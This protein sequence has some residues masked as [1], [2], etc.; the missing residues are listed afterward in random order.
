MK[1]IFLH[2]ET[3]CT[4]DIKRSGV[5]RY[6]Q[7]MSFRLLRLSYSVEGGP[8]CVVDLEH[9]HGIPDEIISAITDNFVRKWAFD[10]HF[11]RVCLSQ[12]F[13]SKSLIADEFLDPYGW[14]CFKVITA[15]FGF[16]LSLEDVEKFRR[17]GGYKS[18]IELEVDIQRK[19]KGYNVPQSIWKEYHLDQEINDRGVRVD[20]D[21]VYNAIEIDDMTRSDILAQMK[22][23]TGLSHPNLPAQMKRWLTSYGIN[24]A[25]LD[26]AAVTDI[27][28]KSENPQVR[29]V[30]S[31]WQSLKKTSIGKYN[32]MNNYVCSDGRARGMFRFYGALRTGRWSSKGIQLHNL[33]QNY[34]SNIELARRIVASGD[35][36]I[37]KSQY[38]DVRA[39][40]SQLIRTAFIPAKGYILIIAD[41]SAIE[42]RVIA[43]LAGETWRLRVFANNE[44]IYCASASKMFGV[45]VVKNGVNG[46]LRAKGKVVELALGYGGSVNALAAMGAADAGITSN[47]L[48]NIVKAWRDSNPC[49]VKFWDDVENA[50]VKAIHS[51]LT[52]T[53]RNIKVHCK[54]DSFMFIE[55]P[56][57][58]C[59]SYPKPELRKSLSGSLEINYKGL[60]SR[61]KQWGNVRTY[62]AKLV[63]N[64]VQG[65]SRDILANAMNN[66]KDYRIVMHVHDEIVIEAKSN[67]NI[68]DVTD[69]MKQTPSWAK[70]LKLDVEAFASSF[71]RKG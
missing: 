16:S 55:L 68:S 17:T 36:N 24:T 10:A 11:M 9:G 14:Y 22:A 69:V 4:L 34:I 13:R 25:S 20:M 39:T 63:E 6:A 38:N 26:K 1:E 61:T 44:D 23:L 19:F 27:I 40:L 50:A 66:L 71:Y 43:W 53:V 21:F 60:D 51:R 12:W 49:I 70:G 45:P 5:Y 32:A 56:S 42:A 28:R 47:G 37:V 62:G 48:P 7:H 59:L 8:V 35:F 67:V 52:H 2:I 58:R 18:P 33:P 3:S 30:L 57:G 54:D 29:Q 41:F 64:I 65:I 15:Y 46:H 31:L